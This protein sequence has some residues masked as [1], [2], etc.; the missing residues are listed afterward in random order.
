MLT[1]REFRILAATGLGLKEHV[2]AQPATAV[3]GS[4]SRPTASAISLALPAAVA[5]ARDCRDD[6]LRV[7]RM[8]VVGAAVGAGSVA[9]HPR[10]ALETPLDHFRAVKSRFD[11]AGI[12]IYG[13]NYSPNIDYTDPEIARGFEM[14]ALGA[15]SRLDDADVRPG[16]NVCRAASDGGRHARALIS[17]IRTSSPRPT[18]FPPR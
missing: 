1:R 18:A 8:R 4:A 15:R 11:A 5:S 12:S 17:P 13:Y 2:F 9:R 7:E 6:R 10:V 16:S 3:S 14:K